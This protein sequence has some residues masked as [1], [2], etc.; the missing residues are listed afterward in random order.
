MFTTAVA[1][2]GVVVGAPPDPDGGTCLPFA[3]PS[4]FGVTEC[5][6]LYAASDFPG[7]LS[8][9]GLTFFL[10]SSISGSSLSNGTFSLALSTVTASVSTFSSLIAVGSDNTQLFSGALP[11]SEPLGASFTLGGGNFSY[12]PANGNLLLDV[13]IS[14][15]T[16][17]GEVFL[18][19][20]HTTT[21]FSRATNGSGTGPTSVGLLT[22]FETGPEPPSSVPEIPEPSSLP[23]VIAGALGLLGFGR[24]HYADG[25]GATVRNTLQ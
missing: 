15:A 21:V 17:A 18:D 9:T 2:A 13:L 16:T 8:V 10:A 6:Q 3:C 23:L 12:N 14:G 19:E 1:S 11:T 7:S 24:F 20:R 4:L 22:Q 25:T 5:Q